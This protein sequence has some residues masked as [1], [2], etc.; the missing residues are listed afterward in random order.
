M[1]FPLIEK[2]LLPTGHNLTTKILVLDYDNTLSDL[3]NLALEPMLFKIIPVHNSNDLLSEL[4]GDKPDVLVV[5]PAING[6]EAWEVC[7]EVRKYSRVPIL[8]LSAINK[9]GIVARALDSGVDDYLIKPI[10]A[11][12]LVAHLNRLTRRA[13][14]EMQA[15]A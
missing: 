13:R 7:Q 10:Q 11:K 1:N 9:P 4:K 14:A 2:R 15:S 12:V 3:L 5:D 6:V 8:A